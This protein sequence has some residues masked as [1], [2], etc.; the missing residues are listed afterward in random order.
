MTQP[1]NRS[2]PYNRNKHEWAS[3]RY[4][5]KSSLGRF[6]V[7]RHALVSCW[8]I[9]KYYGIATKTRW[10]VFSNRLKGYYGRN[11]NV[12]K[13]YWVNPQ[14]IV[15]CSL[16]EFDLQNFKG[17]VIPG[18]WDR[19]E[20]KFCDLDVY[21]AFKYVCLDG[22]KWSDTAFYRQVITQ[23][24]K[25]A[26]LW[27]CKDK[28]D[29][30]RRCES[31]EQLFY[32]IQKHGY[33][34]QSAVSKTLSKTDEMKLEDEVGINI[35]RNG[36]ML[37][38][39]GAHRLAIAKMLGIP[40]IPVKIAVRHT[41]WADLRRELLRY[42]RLHPG[43][44]LPPA[45]HLD[46]DDIVPLN[47]WEKMFSAIRDSTGIKAGRLFDIGP[48]FGYFCQQFEKIGF[49]CYAVDASEEKKFLLER[50]KRAGNYVFNLTDRPSPDHFDIILAL[51]LPGVSGGI[52][53]HESIGIDLL[54][55]IHWKE[56]YLCLPYPT[57]LQ[58][59]TND[60]VYPILRQMH[61]KLNH[62]RIERIPAEL[63]GRVLY[64]LVD[65]VSGSDEVQPVTLSIGM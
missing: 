9:L 46:L 60:S 21:V 50:L 55:N 48:G 39:D 14:D 29:F 24:E 2:Q 17:Q 45:S 7:F 41:G 52:A 65:G 31:L 40:K 16:R 30:E 8:R 62:P 44:K 49:E 15:Y 58:S 27:G 37:F 38:T 57:N 34:S 26:V 59:E 32:T 33:R 1:V 12:D 28:D 25:G 36:D 23:L 4:Y 3:L 42:T 35:G 47:E 10:T 22:G 54:Q 19:L 64:K 56:I 11:F 43:E 6:P 63:N 53:E 61:L 18:D 13:I 20:K 5:A 51:N